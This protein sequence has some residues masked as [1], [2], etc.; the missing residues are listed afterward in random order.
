M[1]NKGIN[2][3]LYKDGR[4]KGLSFKAAWARAYQISK[5]EGSFST[6]F[7]KKDGTT[8]NHDPSVEVVG[9]V[10]VCPET[11]AMVDAFVDM[12]DVED[13][14]K[15]SSCGSMTSEDLNVSE[16]WGHDPSNF[17]DAV[18]LR[19]ALILQMWEDEQGSTKEQRD[20]C[21]KFLNRRGYTHKAVAH[22]MDLHPQTVGKIARS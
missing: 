17:K 22:V 14:M 4:S 20:L 2:W 16:P 13:V 1:S 18:L 10:P 21:I 15:S 9:G 5:P 6:S 7:E 12:A 8:I 19:I 11:R 3:E